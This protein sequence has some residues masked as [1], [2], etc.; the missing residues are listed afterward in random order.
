MTEI[1]LRPKAAPLYPPSIAAP[2]G[3][4][5]LWRFLPTFLRNPLRAL[6]VQVYHEP[7][8]VPP[9]RGR[10][11]WVT[12]P[13]LV[14]EILLGNHESF[15]KS[16]IERRIFKPILGESILVAEGQS[17]RWQRRT[18]APL[19]RHGDL[20]ALVPQMSAAA[21]RM[22]EGWRQS[23]PDQA[24]PIDQDMTGVTFEAVTLPE[25]K[26]QAT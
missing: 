1:A 4:L 6:P 12:E 5:P 26:A 25:V 7:M 14:E 16:P 15:P 8:F 23:V 24:R 18:L 10:L 20:M 3:P 19:F 2:P 22:I 13:K 21:S 17:W 9:M 11:A